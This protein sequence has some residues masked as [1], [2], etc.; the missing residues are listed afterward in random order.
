MTDKEFKRLNR[1]QLIE[2]IYQLQIKQ[3]ELIADNERLAKELEDKRLRISKAGN[4]ADAALE[5]HNVMK[6]VQDAAEHYLEEM[7]IRANEEYQRMIEEANAKAS[8]ILAE[9]GSARQGSGE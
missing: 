2:I 1:S 8:A 3:E 4:L 5:I 7:K 6:S 9:S